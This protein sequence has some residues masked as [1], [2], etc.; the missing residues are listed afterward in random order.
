M[1]NTVTTTVSHICIYS[2]KCDAHTQGDDK[3]N[4]NYGI[5]QAACG[6]WRGAEV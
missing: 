3:Y 4:Y 2:H 1:T 6:Q 5:S